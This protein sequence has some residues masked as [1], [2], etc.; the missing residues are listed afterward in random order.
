MSALTL[1][2]PGVTLRAEGPQHALALAARVYARF[3][4][5][6]YAFPAP[7]ARVAFTE[8][9]RGLVFH[10]PEGEARLAGAEDAGVAL[11]GHIQSRALAGATG[12]RLVHAAVIARAGRATLIAAPSNVGKT[13]LAA[14]LVRAG[15][16]FLSDEAAVL[17]PRG[18]TVFDF[19]RAVSLRAPS[20]DLLRA[21]PSWRDAR[22]RWD[23]EDRFVLDADD[24]RPG[25]AVES[26][27][28]HRVVFLSAPP[29]PPP[30]GLEDCA[31]LEIQTD[32]TPAALVTDL[33]ALPGVR[34]VDVLTDRPAGA[35]RLAHAPGAA[36]SAGIDRAAAAHG[37]RVTGHVRGCTAPL[38]R[39]R[40]PSR[41]ELGSLDGVKRL[42]AHQLNGHAL[43]AAQ[44]PA[45][46]FAGWMETC[47]RA[48]FEEWI[49]GPLD[50]T[51][52][53]LAVD[54]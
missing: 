17:G 36:L 26:A 20:L 5:P 29:A 34:R 46:L 30:P 37:V 8:T 52:A 27:A 19:P 48:R 49:P 53:A 3:T 43:A 15:A 31:F 1:H 38:R 44:G 45:V 18:G 25:C 13:T 12:V 40:P 11:L 51:A 24:L 28:L 23:G 41:R 33:A 14:A 32:P 16:D 42:L 4:G 10:A 9:E 21:P 6:R 47:A 39:D 50:E 35:L 7:E 22:A 2:L 54:L